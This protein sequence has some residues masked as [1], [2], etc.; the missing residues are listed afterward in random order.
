MM[1]LNFLDL[2]FLSVQL[3]FVSKDEKKEAF[4]VQKVTKF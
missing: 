4:W 2:T 1:A 3:M